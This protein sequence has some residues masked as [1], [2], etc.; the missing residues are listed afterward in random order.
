MGTLKHIT[1]GLVFLLSISIL[2]QQG[3]NYK[4]LIKDDGGN[5]VASQNITI[6]FQILKGAGM[7]LQYQETHASVMTD[8]NGIVIVNIGEGTPDSGDYSAIDWGS[9]DHY[10]NVKIDT[11]GGLT[12]L[13]TTP[14]KTVPYSFQAQKADNAHG[15]MRL[16][17]G[18]GIGWR[19]P[20]RGLADQYGPIGLNAVDLSYCSDGSIPRGAMGNFS[21]AIGNHTMATGV[22]ST[23]MGDITRAAGNSSTAMGFGSFAQ[24]DYSTAMGFSTVASNNYSTAMGNDSEAS[25]DT[26]T[27]MGSATM[28]SGGGS[29]AMGKGTNAQGEYSTA[30]GFNTV[31]SH[32][33]STA[34]GNG[35]NA[36]GDTST[37]MGSGTIAF[38]GGTTAMGKGTVAGAYYSTAIGRYNIGNGSGYSW[39][40]TDPLFEI[41]N[42]SSTASRSNA[43]TV[44]KNGNATLAGTLTQN[45]DARLKTEIT[46]LDYGLKTILQLNPVSYYWKKDRKSQT[47]KSIGLIAQEVQ[48][49]LEELVREGHDKDKLLNLDYNGLIPIIINAI[50]EQQQII[51]TQKEEMKDLKSNFESRLKHLEETHN[52]SEQ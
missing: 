2:A 43:F 18:N 44:F 21:T 20:D 6:Q 25:G 34:M 3:I 49:I 24:G 15:L 13:G 14:F 19:I 31:A 35:T 38:G 9:D 23:T 33:Y 39:E 40:P 36:F 10:L 46:N 12:D 50:K 7:S 26:S 52:I 17:Q 22:Y 30:M 48:P 1:T 45:S 11:G 51:E 32:D 29:T 28:A 47:H 37:A 8:A 42:G 41:G 4:A 16:D 5:V 27:A